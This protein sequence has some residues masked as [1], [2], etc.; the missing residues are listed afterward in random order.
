VTARGSK[1]GRALLVGE[2]GGSDGRHAYSNIIKELAVVVRTNLADT[3][4]KA[5]RIGHRPVPESGDF[6]S[7]RDVTPVRIGP[8]LR[9]SHGD[10]RTSRRDPV[11]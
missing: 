5:L 8:Q 2:P 10:Y 4:G 9:N 6:E 11:H 7:N 1:F 3:V